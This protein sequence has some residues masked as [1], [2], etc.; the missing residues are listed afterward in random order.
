MSVDCR[1][2]GPSN[3]ARK[4][5]FGSEEEIIPAF[6]HAEKCKMLCELRAGSVRN[7]DIL[8]L[9]V[10][11]DSLE[12]GFVVCGME[13]FVNPSA[14]WRCADGKEFDTDKHRML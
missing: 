9:K 14:S 10:H 6:L 3:V 5:W 11:D 4:T 13:S 2:L 7:E 8:R 1:D 12:L